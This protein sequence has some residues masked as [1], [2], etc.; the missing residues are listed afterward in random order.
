MN[1]F[2]QLK[3]QEEEMLTLKKDLSITFDKLEVNLTGKE[4]IIRIA[5][6]YARTSISI[7]HKDMLQLIAHLTL[8]YFDDNEV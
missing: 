2:K 8:I 3:K 5:D 7:P 1:K 6:S 4:V